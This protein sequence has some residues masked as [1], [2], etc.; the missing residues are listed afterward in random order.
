MTTPGQH[1][2]D[3]LGGSSVM[4]EVRQL[5]D[6][7]GSTD[8]PIM[9]TGETGTG[10]ELVAQAVHAQS[11]RREGPFVPIN[12]AGLPETLIESELFGYEAGAFTGANQP[13]LGWLELAHKGTAF[14]D[15]IGDMPL[16]SQVKLLHA[17]EQKSWPRL[18]GSRFVSS[19]FRLICATNRDIVQAVQEGTFRQDL[20]HRISV[21]RISM[22]P[23]R[24]RVDDIP[25][26]CEHFLE[27]FEKKV[28]QCASP[29]KL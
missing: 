7:F 14:L 19:D 4:Q 13:K 16:G 3:L 26:L 22:P 11:P 20:Y 24:D 12:C 15:E 8:E 10:K 27:Q 23:L 21:L 1:S 28:E 18:G 25:L 5:I 29:Q 2:T 6:L 9:I 17:L